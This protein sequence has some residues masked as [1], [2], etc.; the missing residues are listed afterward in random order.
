MILSLRPNVLISKNEPFAINLLNNRCY[1]LDKAEYE[2]LTCIENGD[3]EFNLSTSVTS[4]LEKELVQL[5]SN[6]TRL[7]R[8]IDS[9]I[10][11]YFVNSGSLCIM[12]TEK[13]N[14]RCTYCYETFKVGKMSENIITGIEKYLDAN[15]KKF[16]YYS[17]GFFGGEPLLHPNI[18]L[19][20]AKKYRCL[21]KEN[22]IGGSIGITTNGYPLSMEVIEKLNEVEVDFYH[23]SIDGSESIH[24]S[25]RKLINGKATYST[26]LNNIESVLKNTKSKVIF[27]I[28]YD[29]KSTQKELIINWLKDEI[30]PKFSCFSDQIIYNVVSVWQATTT[31]IDGICIKDLQTFNSYFEIQ[32]SICEH[33]NFDSPLDYLL[34]QT[35]EL[36]SLACYAGKPNNYIIGAN[37]KIYKCS[38]AFDLDENN[39]GN[40]MSDGQLLVDS[41]KEELWIS[42]N[43]LT[44][45]QCNKCAFDTR[46][47]GL[48]CPLARIQSSLPPCPTEKKYIEEYISA[49]F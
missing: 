12:P 28:N 26:I 43:S 13:C 16:K 39:I 27:R 1:N 40:I 34:N 41:K 4:L 10:N 48:N 38:V 9:Q 36:G 31:S 22:G 37:G 35:S 24:N 14:F 42:E 30:F 21:Q 25:Q 11:D 23:I 45:K 46:C 7:K 20:I 18:I 19:Q 29:S 2:V 49:N 6:A 33:K 17:L 44:D 8:E 32:K 3:V 5:K 15:L 47:L